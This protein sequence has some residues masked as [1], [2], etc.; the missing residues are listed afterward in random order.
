MLVMIIA[1]A[2]PAATFALRH[3]RSLG[4]S[5]IGID[6]AAEAAYLGRIFCDEFH[7]S[8]LAS[9]PEYLE[10]LS[11]RLAEVDVFLPFIDEELIAIVEGWERITPGLTDRIA[12]SAH[13]V[14]LE[15]TDKCKFQR[16]CEDAGLPIAP[17]ALEAPAFFKP[18]YGRGGRGVA[19]LADSRFFD[20]MRIW[21]YWQEIA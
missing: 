3:L 21:R 4:H 6:A 11:A 13:Q 16:A 8:P 9:S 1:A 2:S 18:L 5:V 7:L 17:A 15:C 20:A 19:S 14:L 12:L 10:F